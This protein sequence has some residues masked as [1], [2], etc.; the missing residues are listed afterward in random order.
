MP[1]AACL[2]T[3]NWPFD[4]LGIERQLATS[5]VFFYLPASDRILGG[6]RVVQLPEP[7]T[8][9]LLALGGLAMLRHRHN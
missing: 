6:F 7:T 3:G 8:L 4:K 2:S 1:G 5:S 9:S